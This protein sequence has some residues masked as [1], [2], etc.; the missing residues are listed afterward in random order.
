MKLPRKPLP[1]TVINN[2]KKLMIL[3]RPLLRFIKDLVAIPISFQVVMMNL[4]RSRPQLEFTNKLPI[5]FL[6]VMMRS[7]NNNNKVVK[8]E[9]I[10]T[11]PTITF[12]E[13]M[14]S[15]LK[16]LPNSHNNN[17]N[18]NRLNSKRLLRLPSRSTILLVVDPTSPW[19]EIY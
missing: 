4:P 18:N 17:N 13:D 12:S 10:P 7:L 14:K 11:N 19:V 6:V 1:I 16:S 8:Q 2:H 3:P 5:T 15:L 9:L